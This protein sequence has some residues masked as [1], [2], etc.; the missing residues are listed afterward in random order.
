MSNKA[1]KSV[2][3]TV[4]AFIAIMA[5]IVS[6]IVAPVGF[7]PFF[8]WAMSDT[9]FLSSS[10]IHS[11]N[12]WTNPGNAFSSNDIYATG[13]DHPLYDEQGYDDFNLSIPSG[14]SIN[15]IEVKVEAKSADT[16]GCRFEVDLSHNN[17]SN[18]SADRNTSSI[19]GTDAVY[20]LGGVADIWGRS[21]AASEFSN[22]NFAVRLR[23]NGSGSSC[24]TNAIVSID[25][26]QVNVTY[27]PPI[28]PAPNPALPNSCGLD[29]AL[30]LD[31]S[32]SISATELGQ[33]KDAFE[34]FVS[35]FLSATPTLFSVT[36]FDHSGHVL[37]TFTGNIALLNTAVNT[38]SSGGQTNWEDGLLKAKSTFDPRNDHPN[39]VIFASDGNPNVRNGNTNP[40]F[41]Q[42]DLDAAVQVANDI[43]GEGTRIIALGIG[44]NLNSDKLK[45]ISSLDAVYTSD[46]STLASTLADLASELC[47]GTIT[48]KKL[49]DGVPAQGWTF[50]ISGS[51]SNPDPVQTGSDGFT[52]SVELE[53]GTYSVEETLQDGYT[54]V[55]AECTINNG[56]WNTVSSGNSVTA[57]PV[58]S[59]DII[60]CVFNNH[61]N[62]PPVITLLGDNPVQL[63][64]NV[65]SYVEPGYTANDPEDGDI[66][67]DVVLSGSVNTTVAGPYVLTY[68]VSD[69][70]GA[71]ATPVT[72]TVNVVA[73]NNE[74]ND[75]L[76]NDDD[77]L[78]DFGQDPGCESLEDTSENQPPVITVDIELVQLSLN[79]VAPV[80]TIG[81]TAADPEDGDIS[82]EIVVGGETVDTDAIGDYTVTYDVEDSDNAAAAQKTRTY[83]VRAQ[84]DDGIDNDLDGDVDFG[85][86]GGDSGCEG[87]SDNDENSP[88]EIELIGLSL[89]SVPAGSLY[90]DAGATAHDNEDDDVP[91]VGVGNVNTNVPGDYTITYDHTD[92]GGLSADQ[93]ARTVTV[94]PYPQCSDDS[95]ND[96]DGFVDAEDPGCW[97]DSSNPQTYNPD[98]NNEGDEPTEIS[99]TP[100]S[101]GGPGDGGGLSTASTGPGVPP[102]TVQPQP[103][104][105][106][107][108]ETACEEYLKEYIKLGAKNNPAEVK[109]LQEFLNKHLGFNL[110]VTGFY[111]LETFAAVNQFQIKYGEQV[112]KPW[113]P[114]GHPNEQTPTGYVYKTTK[115][116]I[117]MVNCPALNLS[118]PLLP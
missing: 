38:P 50:D 6:F 78:V 66:T 4:N 56:S 33:M 104:G 47:G 20:A 15:G 67:G 53:P 9:G 60:S 32:G 70:D 76:D 12:E 113:I 82:S 57:I 36:D 112:L 62:E 13:Y 80:V 94:T 81:V 18:F 71:P 109:K 114:Y 1:H 5:I 59:N 65:D 11:P 93:V 83:E 21:W 111:D 41:Q 79:S 43:K 34:G 107:L 22:N 39:L 42:E 51:P 103:Q 2:L 117:N 24:D 74:C 46:F 118:V 101:T 72:R 16:D 55:A 26:V 29:I 96:E 95:D 48:I 73:G 97:T 10:A 37:Q 27:T 31:S 88:P 64:V 87:P 35:A 17:G 84:C 108:G 61:A 102:P 54:F 7:A 90:V 110:Q 68:N 115:R 19:S 69:S 25:S 86:E 45:A 23:I 58:G 28:Q 105:E 40:S 92:D 14:S 99:P 100:P 116:W 8:A 85:S 89:V 52:P 30:V 3:K 77:G 63:V 98:D 91:V 49:V 75:T 106:V 44:D